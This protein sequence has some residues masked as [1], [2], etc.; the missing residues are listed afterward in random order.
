MAFAPAAR[1]Y[2]HRHDGGQ[3]I[4]VTHGSGFV[5][6]QDGLG[7]PLTAGQSVWT[8]A[9]EVHWHGAGPDSLLTH[10]AYS[11][12]PTEWLGEVS[13]EEYEQAVRDARW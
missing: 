1:T 5:V 10:T 7:A 2:W 4:V 13:D 11:F 12:G 3:L 8:P 9:G 6:G